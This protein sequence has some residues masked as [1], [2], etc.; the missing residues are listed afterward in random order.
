M[1][2]NFI[3]DGRKYTVVVDVG[4]DFKNYKNVCISQFTAETDVEHVW[5]PRVFL[6]TV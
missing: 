3:S 1:T 2:P 6:F 4:T 5:P